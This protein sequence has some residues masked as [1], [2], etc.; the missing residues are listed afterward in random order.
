VTLDSTSYCTTAQQYVED[1]RAD[2]GF[3]KNP[4]LQL[5]T[6]Y[7]N[8]LPDVVAAVYDSAGTF[9]DNSEVRLVY[10]NY[11]FISNLKIDKA[12]KLYIG[13]RQKDIELY[14]AFSK[15][16][17]QCRQIANDP[18]LLCPKEWEDLLAAALDPKKI[19]PSP[20][21]VT[22][23][24]TPQSSES[25]QTDNKA[26][27]ALDIPNQ[28]KNSPIETK[29]PQMTSTQIATALHH[30][31]S[32]HP[33]P[34]ANSGSGGG[35]GWGVPPGGGGN[36]G[37]NPSRNPGGN[38][39][40]GGPG[41]PLP[42]GFLVGGG[43][44]TRMAG[45]LPLIF[46]GDRTKA[47]LFLRALTSY[48]H[49]NERVPPLNTYKGCMAFAM[50]LI[51]GDRV[52]SFI[53]EQADIYDRSFEAPQTWVNFLTAFQER[54]L[55]TQRDTKARQKLESLKLKGI[56]VD[57][58]VQDFRALARDAGYD[59]QEQS[60]WRI[61]LRGLPETI[62]I[63]VWEVPLP[64]TFNELADKT[65]SIVKSQGNPWRHMGDLEPNLPE[66]PT[67]PGPNKRK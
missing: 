64:Q 29:P 65:L 36:P 9:T 32:F 4:Y 52:D 45:A 57:S 46:T 6:K 28:L 10:N 61:Y 38:P 22:T 44:H 62:G 8:H 7:I 34:R 42:G 58:Y 67:T 48:L 20:E 16:E 24:K 59:L 12:G 11:G 15:Q 50:T 40:G 51:Q 19:S 37:G 33:R 56:D 23:P 31:F 3:P 60:V 17:I 63:K 18:K 1:C 47:E 21:P 35:P 30:S 27:R 53:R 26:L 41:A 2:R 39:G 25:A 13:Q 66:V 54:F 5:F 55:D 43:N 14:H 49:L